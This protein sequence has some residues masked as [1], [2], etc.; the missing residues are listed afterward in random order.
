MVKDLD[1]MRRKKTSQLDV[2][3]TDLRM[4]HFTKEFGYQSQKT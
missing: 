1:Q 4:G 3:N 2:K